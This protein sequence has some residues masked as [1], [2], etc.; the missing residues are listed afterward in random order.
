MPFC[1][2]RR[3]LL[4]EELHSNKLKV[5]NYHLLVDV[6]SRRTAFIPAWCHYS[7]C[8]RYC[9]IV[10]QDSI[11][12]FLLKYTEKNICRNRSQ[13]KLY[14]VLV[15]P[16]QWTNANSAFLIGYVTKRLLVLVIR[17]RNLPV[18]LSFFFSPNKYFFK[19]YLLTLLF[20]FL[21]DQLGDTKTIKPFT[22]KGQQPIQLHLMGYLTHSPR[23]MG[24]IVN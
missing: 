21:S 3:K 15:S 16:N 20:P 18:F 2:I 19:L 8:T 5:E 1:Q 11:V 23:A 4:I 14:L 13:H 6:F 22:L 12:S 24:L 17:Q 9:C 10:K 7:F